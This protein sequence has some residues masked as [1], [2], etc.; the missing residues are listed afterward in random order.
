MNI[1]LQFLAAHLTAIGSICTALFVAAVCTMPADPPSTIR[2]CW[3]WL[4]DTLQ[5]AVPAARHRDATPTVPPPTPPLPAPLR[6]IVITDQ[7][8]KEKTTA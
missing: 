1:I 3:C 4:R 7:E 2:Q 5:T 8:N 6:P